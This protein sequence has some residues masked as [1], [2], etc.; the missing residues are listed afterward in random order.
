[1]SEEE[2]KQ[3]IE[4]LLEMQTY[5]FIEENIIKLDLSD[6][7]K[8]RLK[9]EMRKIFLDEDFIGDLADVLERK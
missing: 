6:T 1:M 8:N 4:D 3:E 2:I 9:R 5:N 7:T